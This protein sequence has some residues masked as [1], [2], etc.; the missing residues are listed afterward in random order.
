MKRIL[1][2]L[3]LVPCLGWA[4][5]GSFVHPQYEE[6]PETVSLA[7]VPLTDIMPHELEAPADRG[8]THDDPGDLAETGQHFGSVLADVEWIPVEVPEEMGVEDLLTEQVERTSAITGSGA[9]VNS[10]VG[11]SIYSKNLYAYLYLKPL[12]TIPSTA[13]VST[14]YWTWGLSYRPSGLLVALCHDTTGS[15]I[16]VTSWGSGSTTLFSGRAAN[17]QMIFAFLV[18]GSGTLSPPVYGKMDQVIVNYTY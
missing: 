17:K 12:G 10:G 9:W 11:P 18:S 6:M 16:N 2:A 4:G 13:K 7:P 14:I 3:L 8:L 5:S 1:T 15:C